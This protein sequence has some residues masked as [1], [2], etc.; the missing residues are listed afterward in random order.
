MIRVLH[1]FNQLNQGGIE[2]VVINLMKNMDRSEIE[3]HFALM[4]GK[5]GLLD[6]EVRRLGGHI[7]YFTSGKKGVINVGKNL[8]NIIDKY[9][10]FEVVHSHAYFFSG[11][12]LYIAKMKGVPV[13]IAHAHDTYKGEKQSTKRRI[14]ERLMQKL[15]NKYATYKFGV[16]SDT[17][18]HVFGSIDKNT[19]VIN[20]GINLDAYVFSQEQRDIL[21]KQLD[22][23][24]DEYLLCSIGRF[25]DQKDHNY[26]VDLFNQLLKAD[27]QF[28]LLLV[29]NGSLKTSIINKVKK[30]GLTN[31]VIFLENRN[32]INKLLWASD[33]FILPSKYEGLPVVLV[34]AQATGI[35]CFVSKNITSEIILNQ[36]VYQLDKTYVNN[37]I[38][39][40]E[41]HK[42]DERLSELNNELIQKFDI[43]KIANFVQE[44]Y[45]SNLKI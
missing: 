14:Y 21:R 16:S 29:G 31:K 30:F 32:D 13:R 7:H 19:F 18:K 44:K 4:S 11:Y 34:E 42:D 39:T 40:I 22:I 36:N 9:G 6:D 26:L 24:N 1:V 17:C 23:A 41:K 35:T 45:T 33:G 27:P 5:E 25:E 12:I 43:K 8:S 15:I 10:P 37:W 2:H 28:K 3:F 20:N 38:T